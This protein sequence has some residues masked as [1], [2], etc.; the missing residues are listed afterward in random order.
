MSIFTTTS[1]NISIQLEYPYS[2]E[3]AD[4][5]SL[6]TRTQ[7]WRG[8]GGWE[9]SQGDGGMTIFL[10]RRTISTNKYL[11]CWS[12]SYFPK[13]TASL[14]F[15]PALTCFSGRSSASCSTFLNPGLFL[16]PFPDEPDEPLGKPEPEPPLKPEPPDPEP[17]SQ[18]FL[19]TVLLILWGTF[20][21][22]ARHCCWGTFWQSW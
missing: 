17:P 19:G 3:Q 14:D 15:G 10:R 22:T 20:L 2:W 5:R 16:F 1:Q 7:D 12:K 18:T 11:M 9:G 13:L 4:V 6:W 8:Q 21:W